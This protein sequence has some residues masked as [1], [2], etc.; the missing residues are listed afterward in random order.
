MEKL[1]SGLPFDFCNKCLA[2]VPVE[3]EN[4]FQD[5]IDGFGTVSRVEGEIRG[6]IS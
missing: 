6:T 3:V 2:C 1:A 5:V 4:I